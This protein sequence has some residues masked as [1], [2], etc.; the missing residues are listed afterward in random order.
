M[1]VMAYF[2]GGYIAMCLATFWSFGEVWE[3]DDASEAEEEGEAVEEGEAEW[4][5]PFLIRWSLFFI[6]AGLSGL[7]AAVAAAVALLLSTIKGEFRGALVAAKTLAVGVCFGLS[8][9]C[10]GWMYETSSLFG[11]IVLAVV[12]AAMC[13]SLLHMMGWASSAPE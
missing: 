9:A 10:T 8:G 13:M 11:A 7:G 4:G 1:P 3:P 6:A 12:T 5:W 2:W